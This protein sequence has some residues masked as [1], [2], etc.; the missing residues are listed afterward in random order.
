MKTHITMS[1]IEHTLVATKESITDRLHES[2]KKHGFTIKPTREINP[3]S[4]KIVTYLGKNVLGNLCPMNVNFNRPTIT[5]DCLERVVSL[6]DRSAVLDLNMKQRLLDGANKY[7]VVT[8]NGEYND[9]YLPIE[10]AFCGNKKYTPY[11]D[12]SRRGKYSYPCSFNTSLFSTNLNTIYYGF[13]SEFDNDRSEICDDLKNTLLEIVKKNTGKIDDFYSL[14]FCMCTNCVMNL[15]G[16]N[17]LTSPRIIG[18]C[19]P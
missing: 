16:V 13:G 2:A 12:G 15:M 10:C 3:V 4:G 17:S 7:F 9:S 11:N 8:A 5:M 1:S 14:D 19:F 6:F 18:M